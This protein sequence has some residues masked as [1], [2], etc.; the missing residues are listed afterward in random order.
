MRDYIVTILL[1]GVAGSHLDLATVFQSCPLIY[2]TLLSLSL[3][4][5]ILWLYS[6]FTLRINDYMPPEFTQNVRQ[7]L[8]EQ[9]FELALE[10]CQHSKNFCA[11]ILATGLQSRKHGP[12]VMMDMVQLEGRRQ[13]NGLWQRISLLNEIAVIA[14]MI[15]LLGTVLGLFMAFYN[16][17]HSNESL[18]SIFDGFGIALGT[19]V[20]GLIVAI[21]AMIFYVSLKY[22][23]VNLLSMVQT[24]SLALISLVE[25]E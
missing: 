3:V 7:L 11:P 6:M 8:S 21:L 2:A 14:P 24:E 10:T 12:Q 16:S 18:A 20:A 25:T 23:V 19:T 17:G 1:S 4:A 15:G 22:R 13:A 9:H 5:T